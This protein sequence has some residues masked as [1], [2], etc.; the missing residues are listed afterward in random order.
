MIMYLMLVELKSKIYNY[1]F[2][3]SLLV[4]FNLVMIFR[5]NTVEYVSSVT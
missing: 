3:E 1:I 5:I 2:L 4:M